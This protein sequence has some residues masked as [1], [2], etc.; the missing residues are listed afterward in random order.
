MET[1]EN[2]LN[3]LPRFID[4]GKGLDGR[5]LHYEN[6]KCGL[7]RLVDKS[8]SPSCWSIAEV[9]SLLVYP[10]SWVSIKLN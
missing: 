5:Y 9:V 1:Y 8:G 6:I 7:K 2:A 3:F 10:S 4:A